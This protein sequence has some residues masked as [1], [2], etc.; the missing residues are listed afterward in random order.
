LV[1]LSALLFP[2]SY[3]WEFCFPFSVHAQTHIIYVPLL[4]LL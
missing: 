2:H 4:S 3:F 1:C